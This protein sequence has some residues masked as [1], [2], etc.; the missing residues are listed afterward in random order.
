MFG[1]IPSPGWMNRTE[2]NE[3]NEVS[4]KGAGSPVVTGLKTL[5]YLLLNRLI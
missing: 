5:R 4:S 2:G 1:K 3:V